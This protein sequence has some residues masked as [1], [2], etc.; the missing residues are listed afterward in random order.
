M[1]GEEPPG[2]GAEFLLSSRMP[3]FNVSQDDNILFYFT[4]CRPLFS[5]DATILGGGGSVGGG[6]GGGI[7]FALRGVAF[8]LVWAVFWVGDL[9]VLW[10]GRGTVGGW[11]RTGVLV[12]FNEGPDFQ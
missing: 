1:V 4:F 2:V 11:P 12:G 7:L 3:S 8:C 10:I 9:S 6:S 5:C